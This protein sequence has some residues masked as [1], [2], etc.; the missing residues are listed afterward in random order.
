MSAD[1]AKEVGRL[2]AGGATVEQIARAVDRSPRQVHRILSKLRADENRAAPP[3][4]L[5]SRILAR[6]ERAAESGNVGAD[7]ALLDELAREE[8]VAE[9]TSVTN[10][11]ARAWASEA[12]AKLGD[13]LRDH[14]DPHLRELYRKCTGTL[15]SEADRER[16]IEAARNAGAMA[17]IRG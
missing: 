15:V 2:N 16:L 10:E 9:F 14:E 5:R 11:L 17:V 12:G 4:D 3:T 7:K 8:S 6:L 1:I 13:W